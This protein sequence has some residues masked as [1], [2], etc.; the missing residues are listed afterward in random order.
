[1]KEDMRSTA[2]YQE[3]EALFQKIRK[4]G[5]G[6]LSDAAEIDVSPDGR[7]AV[8]AG[9]QIDALEGSP[10]SRI[11]MT[12]L[13]TGDTRILTAG[14]NTDRL[15]KFSPDGHHVEIGRAHV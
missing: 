10:P 7:W 3:A 1:M 13:S 5:T 12:D 11:C 15:P 2:S 14:P 4:P 6:Q 9:T 8:F